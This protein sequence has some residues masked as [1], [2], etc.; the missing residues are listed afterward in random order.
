MPATNEEIKWGANLV[1][2]VG[3]KM[4]CVTSFDDPFKA[5]LKV[6][7]EI[8][9]E[10]CTQTGFEPAPYLARAKWVLIS[11]SSGLSKAGWISM[12]EQSYRLVASR[13]TKKQRAELGLN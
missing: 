9:E 7:D 8:F 5:S 13:L 11:K 12:V 10:L 3:G 2:T 6:P 1:F 4:F